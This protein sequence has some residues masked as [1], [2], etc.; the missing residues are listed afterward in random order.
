MMS[1][2][3]ETDRISAIST[4]WI[5]PLTKMASSLVTR[6]VMPCGRVCWIFSAAA[7]TPSEMSSVFDCAWR[8]MPMPMPVLPSERSEETPMSGPSVTVA[9]SPSR[10]FSPMTMFSKASGV[11]TEAVVRTMMFWALVLS[12]PAG[13]SSAIEASALRMS[14][15]VR[16]TL[17]SLV[18][19]MSTRKIFSR[20]P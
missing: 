12:E 17:A 4:S 20:S 7:R 14:A 9:T 19:L 11:V 1:S 16:P 13:V 18:W 3:I 2:T 5:A 8:M 10:V 15:M 6:M